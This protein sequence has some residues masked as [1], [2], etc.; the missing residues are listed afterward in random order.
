MNKATIDGL[1]IAGKDLRLTAPFKFHDIEAQGVSDHPE[2]NSGH[3][4]EK[5]R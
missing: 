4:F 1:E 2:H 3:K 5:A